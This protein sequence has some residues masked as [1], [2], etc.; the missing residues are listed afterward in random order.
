MT[1]QRGYR[2]RQR[3]NDQQLLKVIVTL[4]KELLTELDIVVTHYKQEDRSFNRSALIHEALAL[5]LQSL[6]E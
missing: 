6:D 4:P 2:G 1:T 5:Y 3:G